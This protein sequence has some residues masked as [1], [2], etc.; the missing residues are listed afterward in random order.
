MNREDALVV[1]KEAFQI[2]ADLLAEAVSID[3]SGYITNYVFH[4]IRLFERLNK[5]GLTRFDDQ[6]LVKLS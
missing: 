1:L 2:C 6:C 4:K 5:R 3:T